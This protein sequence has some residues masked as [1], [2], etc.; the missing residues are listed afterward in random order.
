M[1]KLLNP[2][3]YLPVRQTA[4]WGLAVMIMTA[5]Y[6]WLLPLKMTSLT[7]IM[8]LTEPQRLWVSTLEQLTVWV[9][10]T[11]ILYLLASVFSKSRVR[12]QD[13]AAFNLFAR[14]PISLMLLLLAIPELRDM[15]F[16][17]Q[18]LAE[19]LTSGVSQ[20]L[21]SLESYLVPMLLFAVVSLLCAVWYFYWSYK[22]FAESTNVKNGQGIALFIVGFVIAYFVSGYILA[23]I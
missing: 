10:F 12:L 18:H 21:T 6:S 16:E 1:K 8:L 13:V 20:D 4:C 2:F 7:Q 15:M 3:R 22:G 23:A 11:L 9:V 19:A 5:I 14:L 17:M